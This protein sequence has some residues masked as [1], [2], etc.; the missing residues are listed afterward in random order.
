M[1]WVK[2][3]CFLICIWGSANC[4]MINDLRE[5]EK[6]LQTLV[7]SQENAADCAKMAMNCW[8]VADDLLNNVFDIFNFFE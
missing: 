4:M 3:F 5:L 2:I 6:T 8:F 1:N 7:I